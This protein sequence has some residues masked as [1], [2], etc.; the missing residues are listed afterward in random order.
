MAKWYVYIDD[1]RK[2]N[3]A[4][5]AQYIWSC[6]V[7]GLSTCLTCRDYQATIDTLKELAENNDQLVIDLDLDLGPVKNMIFANGFWKIIIQLP[8]F[9][10]T[11]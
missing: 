5:N 6:Y 10:F 9:I 11:P 8:H 7:H 4:T 3:P 2:I 1:E